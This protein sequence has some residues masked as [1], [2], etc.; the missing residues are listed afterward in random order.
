MTTTTV[1]KKIGRPMN[2][3]MTFRLEKYP[4]IQRQSPKI[5]H[6]DISKVIAKWWKEMPDHEKEP[7][8]TQ[9]SKARAEHE[10]K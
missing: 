9:A 1:T 6:R 5:N 3:F 4:E 7:Y 8:R 10:K 2:C